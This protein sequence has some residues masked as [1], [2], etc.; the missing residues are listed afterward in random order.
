MVFVISSTGM[1]LMPTKEYKARKLLKKGKA[2]IYCYRPFTI[3]LTKRTA[4]STQPIEY[5]CDT[6]YQNIGVSVCSEKHEFVHNEY[7]LLSDETERHNDCRKH[8]RARRN[9]LRYRKASWNNRK[10]IAAKDGFAPSIR[11]KRDVHIRLFEMYSRVCPI[12][13]A[14]FEMGQFDTQLLKA[15][16]EGKP[17]PEGTDYQRGERYGTATLREVV[18]AR[19]NYA[20]ICCN[21]SAIK[22][23]AILHVHHI[24]FWKG[25]RTNRL[26]NLATVCEKCHTPKNHKQGGKLYGLEP[27][28]KAFKGATFMTMVRY[29]MFAKLKTAA[30]DV[31]FC[32]TYGALT[33][34]KRKSLGLKKSHANDAYSMGKLHP[35]HKTK[36][37]YYQKLRR[38]NR[39]LSKFYDAKYVDIRD[40]SIKSGS[41]IGCNRTNRR[42]LRN[43]DKNERIYRG[44]QV[45]KGRISVRRQH[46]SYRPYDK[47]FVDRTWYI[48]KG[49]QNNGTYVALQGYKP[50]AIS[51]IQKVKHCGAWGAA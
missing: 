47:V 37:I 18:F 45:S 29:D 23:K 38:N 40:G 49:V 42:E 35:K 51:R 32:M 34:L 41:Q 7:K 10:G 50:V 44:R 33:K 19:D 16:E 31:E 12:T 39:I 36:A 28:L 21:R 5:K 8:R 26:A 13:S 3:K 4:G 2:V 17:L 14:A 46:Y 43:S 22:D 11:N 25:D 48:V 30:S 6:G 15:V 1:R 20:C 9:R 27:K 24:G